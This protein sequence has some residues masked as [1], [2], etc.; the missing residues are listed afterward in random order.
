[1]LFTRND[2]TGPRIIKA[3]RLYGGKGRFREKVCFRMMPRTLKILD[4]LVKKKWVW[5][6]HRCNRGTVV[7]HLARV[8]WWQTNGYEWPDTALSTKTLLLMHVENKVGP[9]IGR[10][11]DWIVGWAYVYSGGRLKIY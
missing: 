5:R 9:N 7:D 1:M 8:Y 2:V 11:L 10:V 3:L 4:Y 6:N